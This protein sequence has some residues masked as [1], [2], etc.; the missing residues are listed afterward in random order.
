M[1][2][3]I[4]D[5]ENIALSTSLHALTRTYTHTN[6]NAAA[7]ACK[8]D[9]C[10]CVC[11]CEDKV[12]LVILTGYVFEELRLFQYVCGWVFMCNFIQNTKIHI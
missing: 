3:I 2:S 11:M 8:R 10:T 12:I 7:S 1:Q 4:K 9:Y 5:M 6:T